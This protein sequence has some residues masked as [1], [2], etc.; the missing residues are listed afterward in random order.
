VTPE[1]FRRVDKLVSLALE[2]AAEERAEFIR[3]ACAG[4]EDL[5][6]EVESLLASYGKKDK[7]LAE[8]PARL[9]A[10][11]LAE[12]AGHLDSAST[13]L[14]IGGLAT[15]RYKLVDKLGV[16]GMGVVYLAED[17]QLGRKVAIKLMEPK[18]AITQL[19]S[20]GR[21]RLLREAQALAQL[22]HPNVIAVYDVGTCAD[23][24]FIAMEYVEGSTLSRWL[25]ER[26]RSWREVLSTFLQ[27]GRGLAAAHAAGIVH[28]DFKPD[29]VLV[30]NDGR[31][32]VLD[33]GLARPAQPS[34]SEELHN[35]DGQAFADPKTPP[36]LAQLGV[37]V[38]QPGKFIGTP[39]FMAP[40]QLTGERVNE[41]TDQY[42]FCVALFQ[43]LYDALP[44]NADNFAALLLQITQRKVNRVP[45]LN[46]VPSSVHQALLRGLS[47]EPADRFSSMEALLEELERYQLG[48][49]PVAGADATAERTEGPPLAS[50]T[51]TQEGKHLDQ[52]SPGSGEGNASGL[53]PLGVV[54]ADFNGDGF[55]D[56]AVANSRDATVSIML[57]HGDGT[58][59]RPVA[60]AAGPGAAG[61][62]SNW[63]AELKRRRVFRAL[64]GALSLAG[65][66]ALAAAPGLWYYFVERR[67][68]RS[69]STGVSDSAASTTKHLAVLRLRNVSG[70][71]SNQALGDGLTELL[72][73]K[74]SQVAQLQGEVDKLRGSLSV[75]PASEVLKG[76]KQEVTSAQE[77]RSV[78]GAALMVEGSIQRM[79]G[80]VIVTF[81]LVDT[82]SHTILD[83]GDVSAPGEQLSQLQDSFLSKVSEMLKVHLKPE[84]RR[85]LAAELPKNPGAYEFYLQGRGH[86]QRYDRVENLDSAVAV[87][88]KALA[89]DSGYA[90]AYAGL[91]EA[92]LR[93]YNATKAPELISQARNSAHR[94][95]ELNATLAP[96]H[97][98]MGLIHAAGGEYE[99]A[100]ERFKSSIKIQPEPDAYRELANS[101]DSSNR[102]KGAEATYRNAIQMRP[103]Y[104]AGYRD[105]AVFY[106][107]HGR[108]K[109]ALPLFEKVIQLTPDNYAGWANLGGLYLR[110][111]MQAKAIECFERANSITPT[112][113]AYHNLGTAFYQLKRYED[114]IEMYQKATQLMPTG[115]AAWAALGD[116][117]RRMPQSENAMRGA[118]A[119]AIE[120]TERELLVNPSDGQNWAR[121][122]TWRVV[123]EHEKALNDIREALRLSPED[124]FVQARAASV[125]EQ[126]DMRDRALAAVKAAVEVGFSRAELE[127]W[128]PLQRLLQDPRYKAF[129][130]GTAPPSQRSHRR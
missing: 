62:S 51:Q 52:P 110:Q 36:R 54:A 87:F 57:G 34:R 59:A 23:Q 56:L 29:N 17:P 11:L 64:V 44:F 90:L 117:Y 3:A 16:G 65:I 128:P 58:F 15:G 8:A 28:R 7:F 108:F 123:T 78:L 41:K 77:A 22:S 42:S 85:A 63:F 75:I 115:A 46:S 92:Y 118:Y 76:G 98:A 68:A 66:G 95:L 129:I 109:E 21:A 114:A 55:V 1:R 97:Y 9:A 84:A 107:N 26:K 47:P 83:S 122:A 73:N 119:H 106:Q 60:Y 111:G 61:I 70:D 45:N 24:V 126:S 96:V 81:S 130:E 13:E 20:E 5:R 101:Y 19:A 121:L 30:G 120:L 104:W 69:L 31:V 91:A 86:L 99:L 113:G 53:V 74:L 80:R 38:T 124:G 25:A 72:T 103:T 10:E 82:A 2:R 48:G 127:S 12:S 100:V 37:T 88:Q 40:E 6:I 89:R 4:E 43:G 14:A 32:R 79:D 35:A 50:R 112:Y 67:S 49:A 71:Q 93:K 125:Y 27:A 18:T 102:P 39:A 105:L 94:A 33:F 116:L